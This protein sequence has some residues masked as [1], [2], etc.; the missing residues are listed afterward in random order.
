[1]CNGSKK[2]GHGTQ[3]QNT[4]KKIAEN[5]NTGCNPCSNIVFIKD[6]FS[7]P[8]VSINGLQESNLIYHILRDIIG[9]WNTCYYIL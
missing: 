9:N 7:K 4:A 8:S 1:M 6:S 5:V 2:L 3:K